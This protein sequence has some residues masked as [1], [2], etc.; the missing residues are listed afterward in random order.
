MRTR[1]WAST[2]RQ[3][4]HLHLPCHGQYTSDSNAARLTS[5]LGIPV[6]ELDYDQRPYP[7]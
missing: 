6:D 4:I 3:D 7:L 2:Y 1:Q 5:E